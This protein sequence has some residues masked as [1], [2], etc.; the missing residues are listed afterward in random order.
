[1]WI[2]LILEFRLV[3]VIWVA[4]EK[5]K[6]HDKQIRIKDAIG[7]PSYI[8]E[9]KGHVEL[10]LWLTMILEFSLFFPYLGLPWKDE[11][12]WQPNLGQWCKSVPSYVY[13]VKGYVELFYASYYDIGVQVSWSPITIK[14]DL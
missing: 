8:N 14:L 3:F 11:V 7:V 4:F 1:M 9:V 13:E 12:P 6:S 10:F 2:T 5:W